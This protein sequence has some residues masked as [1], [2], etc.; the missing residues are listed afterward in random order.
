MK[1]RQERETIAASLLA[2]IG[3]IDQTLFSS[4]AKWWWNNGA[5]F[6]IPDFAALVAK[7]DEQMS[8]A[9]IVT[10]EHMLHDGQRLA[11]TATSL[12]HLKNGKTYANRYMFLITFDGAK[13]TE[14]REYS[15]TAHVYETFDLSELM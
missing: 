8:E 3:L 12:G 7:L 4:N 14:V 2:G 15:D 10:A 6:T 9:I 13:I 5:E 11:I 1:V